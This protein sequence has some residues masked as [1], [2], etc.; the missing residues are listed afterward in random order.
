MTGVLLL[1]ATLAAG[2]ADVSAPAGFRA[3]ARAWLL[4]MVVEPAKRECARN[5]AAQGT[6][7]LEMNSRGQI[8]IVSLSSGDEVL[9]GCIRR[10]VLETDDYQRDLPYSD[11][12]LSFPLVVDKPRQG[13]VFDDVQF[14]EP[15]A[16]GALCR[17]LTECGA[18]QICDANPSGGTSKNAG[19]CVDYQRWLASRRPGPSAK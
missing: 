4:E 11:I 8:R 7:R 1:V 12:V 15:R 5:G 17:D 6:A 19:W 16:P 2:P 13:A 9:S 10:L 3:Q 18:G 14:R